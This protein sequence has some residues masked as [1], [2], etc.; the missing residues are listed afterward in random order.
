MM[1]PSSPAASSS[2]NSTSSCSSTPISPDNLTVQLLARLDTQSYT[3]ALTTDA[4]TLSHHFL[5]PHDFPWARFRRYYDKEVPPSRETF[6]VKELPF[7]IDELDAIC[8][9]S[10]R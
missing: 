7:D 8:Y 10:E 4:D 6:V 2:S 5:L 9:Y 1:V 3:N